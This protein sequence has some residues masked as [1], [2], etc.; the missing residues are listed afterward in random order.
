MGFEKKKSSSTVDLPISMPSSPEAPPATVS[1]RFNWVS[2]P[3][4]FKILRV[5]LL[6][7]FSHLG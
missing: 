4:L 3:L 2:S 5:N 1:S 6:M 7:I